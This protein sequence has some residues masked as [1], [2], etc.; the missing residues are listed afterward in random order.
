MWFATND[1]L[2]KSDGME[3]STYYLNALNTKNINTSHINCVYTDIHGNL[4][5]G[6]F[7]L[8]RYNYDLDSIVHYSD[9]DTV[10]I[11]GRIR[12]M[13]NDNNG[14]FWIGST[15]GLFSYYYE[16]DTL[17]YHPFPLRKNFE[18]LAI[19]P[20]HDKI[21]I[22]IKKYGLYSYDVATGEF[23]PIAIPGLPNDDKIVDLYMQGNDTLWAGTLAHGIF[24][25]NLSDSSLRNIF[26]ADNILANK[27]RKI[28]ADNDGNTWI[29][30]RGGVYIKYPDNDSIYPFPYNKQQI[31]SNS[32][33]DIYIDDH[34][35]LWVGTLAGGVKYV[36]LKSKPFY[37]FSNDKDNIAKLNDHLVY[38]ICED[39]E[40][41][42]YIGTDKG[43]VNFLDRKSREFTYYK[44]DPKSPSSISS[45]NVKCFAMDDSGNLWMGTHGGGINYFNVKTK[46]FTSCKHNINDS[47]SIISNDVYELLLDEKQDLWIAT[48]KG[49][50]RLNKGSTRFEHISDKIRIL[51]I[52]ID[53]AGRVW[54]G[55]DDSG[56]ILYDE[57]V[58]RFKPFLPESICFTVKSICSDSRNH[59]WLATN[60][61]LYYLNLKDSSLHNYTRNNSNLPT[62]LII[63][64][65]EDEKQNLWVSTSDG[66]VKCINAVN[67]PLDFSIRTFS[68]KDGL[69]NKHFLNYSCY[70]S[71]TGMLIFGGING[72]TM[73]YPDSLNDNPYCPRPAFTRFKVYNKEVE[74]GRKVEETVILNKQINCCEEVVL[75]HRHNIFTI[76]FAALHYANP[77]KNLYKYRLF[78]FETG[79]NYT[80]ASR[81]FASY[82]NLPYGDYTFMVAVANCDGLW[83]KEIKTLKITILPPFWK[84][85]WFKSLLVILLVFVVSFFYLYK[86]QKIKKQTDKLERIVKERTREIIQKNELLKKKTTDLL[87]TNSLLEEQKEQI[88]EQSQILEE[89]KEELVVQKDMLKDL[90][91]MKDKFFSI[92]S[93]DLKSPF[94]G[95]MGLANILQTEYDEISEAEKKDYIKTISFTSKNV[96]NL[97]ENLLYWS[98]FQI[99]HVAFKPEL[100]NLADLINKNITLLNERLMAKNIIF[101][102]QYNAETAIFA[103]TN[104]LDT[105]IRNLI[106]N[107]VKYTRKGGKI[108]LIVSDKDNKKTVCCKDNGIGLSSEIQQNLFRIDKQ[109][110]MR[111]T[112]NEP[113]TGLGLIICRDFIKK[114]GGDIWVESSPGKGSSFF[115]T[116]P[117][118]SKN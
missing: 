14:T 82:T 49:V 61:G 73:F 114:H 67:N 74:V 57:K 28:V 62:S 37:N 96:Y 112:E 115:F 59:L 113:G 60:N 68:I 43:G 30:T 56:I 11:T 29:G 45:N 116:I 55:I 92:I 25:L 2:S 75:N 70:K 93:H 91:A 117:M 98:R 95:I 72:F 47:S 66:L 58:G 16:R 51:C 5:I 41:N 17:V 23:Q 109:I 53:L 40:G 89:Q 99:N 54:A 110:K 80:E 77:D 107:A 1:G 88:T 13:K 79:W 87:A 35:N 22:S 36:N 26:P 24:L 94:H 27:V 48:K 31:Y 104:M 108:S 101:T 69:Q 100:T 63:K 90:N 20:Y 78:P 18:V 15:K 21:Y 64:I 85:L 76:E 32:V 38:G 34:E 105:V 83:N 39:K 84:T 42:L 118:N 50:D 10:L 65:L 7:S 46:Q 102:K 19:V 71:S 9:K 52:S 33:F 81:R 3:L 97:L 103:D 8:F 111:G 12:D 86:I 4:W 44:H 6:A 106:S